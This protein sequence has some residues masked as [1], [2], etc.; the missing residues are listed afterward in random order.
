MVKKDILI[1]RLEEIS[2]S[3]KETNKVLAVL[4]LGSCGKERDRLDEFSDLDFFVIVKDGYKNQFLNHLD[5]LS[6]IKPIEFS[7][8]NTVD[9]HKV[10]FVDGV[11]CEFAIFETGELSEIPFAEG[12]IIWKEDGFDAELCK[13]S[14]KKHDYHDNNWLIGEILTT[15]YVGLGR[16]KRGEKLSAYFLIQHRCVERLV[17]LLRM[18]SNVNN[19]NLDLFNESRRFEGNFQNNIEEFSRFMLGYDNTLESAENIMKYLESNYT[20]NQEFSHRI[21]ELVVAK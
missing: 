19:L 10:M 13:P 14:Y 16:Y 4:A 11:F 3:L 6:S 12:E 21:Y 2:Q 5:W 17:S 8:Q 15:I 1:H 20:I 7:Y 9:G 18:N